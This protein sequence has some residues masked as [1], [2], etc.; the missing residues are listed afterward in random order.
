MISRGP[1]FCGTGWP[2]ALRIAIAAGVI[3]L[4]SI[5]SPLSLSKKRVVAD[6]RRGHEA[7]KQG[8]IVRIAHHGA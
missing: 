4:R 7:L 2:I 8:R 6:A 1:T 3:F 5:R